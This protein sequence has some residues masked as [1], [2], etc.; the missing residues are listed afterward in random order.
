MEEGLE[1]GIVL[2]NKERDRFLASLEAN[3]EPSKRM[4]KAAQD[5]KN[6]VVWLEVR[7]NF[8]DNIMADKALEE[9]DFMDL[10]EFW[11]EIEKE[12]DNDS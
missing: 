11:R 10:D 8:I 4:K 5:Y 1:K 9:G 6:K 3:K 12:I 2:N 7:D